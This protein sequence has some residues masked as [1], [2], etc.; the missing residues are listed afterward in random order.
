MDASLRWHD[1]GLLFEYVRINMSGKAGH[2]TQSKHNV[3]AINVG[4]FLVC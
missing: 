3:I 4:L 2:A 1:S